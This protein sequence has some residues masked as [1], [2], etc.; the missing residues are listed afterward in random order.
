MELRHLS[1]FQA[2][3]LEL[4]FRRA[5]DRLFISQ[6]GLSRQI[7]QLE[8]ELE[9]QLFDRS[10]K[11]VRLTAAGKHLKDE[12]DF[13]LNHLDFTK[14]QLKLIQAGK[15]G[16]IRIGFLGSASNQILPNL[17]SKLNEKEPLISVS[18]EELNNTSQ[19]DLVQ[20][21]K[22]DLGFVRLASVPEGLRIRPI[23][24]DSFSLVVPLDHPINETD[25]KSVGQFASESFI[26]FSSE[27]SSLYYE[28]II[29][30]CKEAGFSPQIRFQA[31]NALTIFKLVESGLGVAI[32]PTSLKE[33]YDLQVRFM[34]IP[35]L[36]QFAELSI[37]WKTENRNPV[38]K[39]IL[40]LI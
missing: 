33:G 3:A 10:Q 30:I 8:A 25:F 40:D 5:A 13:I 21:D 11:K 6:P 39:K 14:N 16:K 27:Y 29:G 18:L 15:V 28:Q 2:V 4:N 34:E 22:L 26:L 23:F 7:Q 37:I 38:L 9:V 32:V 1:Y 12:V 36:I 17:L 20:K 19:V 35:L 24:K 31:V